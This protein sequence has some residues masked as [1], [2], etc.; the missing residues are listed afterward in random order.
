MIFK[1]FLSINPR[2][3]CRSLFIYHFISGSDLFSRKSAQFA[4]LDTLL[5]K[6]LFI[7][8]SGDGMMGYTL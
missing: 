4:T 8:I 5:D 7:T 3:N 2:I 6:L 1:K